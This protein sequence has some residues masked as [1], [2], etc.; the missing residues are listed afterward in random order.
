MQQL[1]TNES[2]KMDTLA[3]W[4]SWNTVTVYL[5]SPKLWLWG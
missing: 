2:L 1:A 4:Q 5:T 3:V